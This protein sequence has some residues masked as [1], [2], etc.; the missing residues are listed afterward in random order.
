MASG[1]VV[2]DLTP[3]LRKALVCR[4]LLVFRAPQS[5]TGS[6]K[7]GP[8]IAGDVGQ[9]VLWAI[10][11]SFAASFMSSPVWP[12][13][14]VAVRAVVFVV[15]G[16]ITISTGAALYELWYFSTTF[17]GSVENALRGTV[18]SILISATRS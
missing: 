11:L 18:S 5:L 3:A 12:R 10:L 14:S 16:L 13:Y 9:A 15:L 1:G 17:L 4:R 2:T 8:I 6:G 7:V